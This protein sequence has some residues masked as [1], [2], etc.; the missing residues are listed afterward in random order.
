[1]LRIASRL[2]LA[3]RE[4]QQVAKEEKADLVGK[5]ARKLAAA[6][7][8]MIQISSGPYPS[9]MRVPLV[10]LINAVQAAVDL[11]L[12]I[13]TVDPDAMR[14]ALE[15]LVRPAVLR[16]PH[17]GPRLM[18]S[19]I[20]MALD[21]PATLAVRLGVPA[22]PVGADERFSLAMNVLDRALFLKFPFERIMIDPVVMPLSGRW[23]QEYARQCLVLLQRLEQS[24]DPPVRTLVNFDDF[25]FDLPD[26]ERS[27]YGRTYLALLLERG[28][29]AAVFDLVDRELRE[30][31][32]AAL[33]LH[34]VLPF[35]TAGKPAVAAAD[36]GATANNGAPRAS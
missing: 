28:L 29:D 34:G 31:V 25:L 23:G 14:A 22:V 21:K 24:A 19:I 9:G 4:V 5:L 8:D 2:S 12:C 16:G 35:E 7:A 33:T 17:A 30:T 15:V 26:D 6:G 36:G 11:P 20:P 1:M 13:E 32:R 27:L 18:E 3:H 10:F